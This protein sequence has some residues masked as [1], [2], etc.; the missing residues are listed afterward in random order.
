MRYALL[1][2]AI[3]LGACDSDGAWVLPEA[4]AI[5]IVRAEMSARGI[6]AGDTRRQI[7]G[8]EVCLT[9]DT[10]RPVTI[11]LDGWDAE[12]RVGFA[13]ISASDRVGQPPSSVTERDEADA[14]QAQLDARAE[15]EGVVLVF[16]EWA[17]ETADLAREQFRS[18]VRRTLDEHG[19]VE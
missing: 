5:T 2:A 8:I 12:E 9:A 15:R 7:D 1:L 16:R 3:G 14:I 17:H 6:E 19:L 11:T 10:C 4:E 13:Y 18:A